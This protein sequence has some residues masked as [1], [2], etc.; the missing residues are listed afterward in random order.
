M[1]AGT[2]QRLQNA[3]D[4]QIHINDNVLS[5]VENYTYLGLNVNEN[6]SW[7]K[8]ILHLC[9]KLAQKVNVLR[10]L[11]NILPKELLLC[12]YNT[13]IQPHIDYCITVWGYAPNVHIDKVQRIQNRA[14]RIIT[15]NFSWDASGT[16]LVKSLG[17]FTV[18]QRRDYFTGV[19]MHRC[20]HEAAPP[21]L[22]Q[23]FM[24]VSDHHNRCTRSATGNNLYIPKPNIDLYR[25]SLSYNGPTTWNSIPSDIKS[26]E[27]QSA[28]K[29]MYKYY[30]KM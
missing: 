23:Q 5:E 1:M 18:R 26:L 20:L 17:W 14:A 21:Y 12:I 30:V 28:F 11:K 22:C 29:N 15:G 8:Y 27:G 16:E 6:L 10:R 4:L 2:C 3:S 13:V 25:Q 7:G 24:Y 9:S 19:L